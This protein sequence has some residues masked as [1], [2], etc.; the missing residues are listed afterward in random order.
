M[1]LAALEREAA[2]AGVLSSRASWRPSGS[3]ETRLPTPPTSWRGGGQHGI[4]DDAFSNAGA[5]GLG[6]MLEEIAA[7]L[8][9]RTGGWPRRAGPALF[10]EGADGTP[11]LFGSPTDL[12]AWLRAQFPVVWHAAPTRSPRTSSSPT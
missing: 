7:D 2:V 10:C 8:M 1:T 12:F 11:D 4:K 9:E 5:D 3:T 6:R